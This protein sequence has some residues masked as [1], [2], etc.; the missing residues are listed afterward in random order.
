M[1]AK[2]VAGQKYHGQLITTFYTPT[3]GGSRA[4]LTDTRSTL[5]ISILS[6]S[7]PNVSHDLPFP[8]SLIP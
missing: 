3:H 1:G 6:F 5:N 8:P 2:P 7:P 4:S